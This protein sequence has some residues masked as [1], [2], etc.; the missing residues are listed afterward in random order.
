MMIKFIFKIKYFYSITLLLLL[1]QVCIGQTK[2]TLSNLSDTSQ[3]VA[4]S[5]NAPSISGYYTGHNSLYREEFAEKYYLS[6]T[7]AVVGVISFH[8][9]VNKNNNTAEFNIYEVASSR[10]PG[11]IL[12]S[13]KILYK[14]IDLQRNP[15]TT[16]FENP[17]MVQDSFF[18]SFNL[19]DYAHG[20]FEG[21]KIALLTGLD[22]SR[23][24]DDLQHSGRN[25]IRVHNHD[26]RL[27]RD[28]YTQNFTPVAT[29]FAIY[30]IVEFSSV[31]STENAFVTDENLT[32]HPTFPNPIS[33][34][35]V[36][37][38]SLAH[39]SDVQLTIYDHVGKVVYSSLNQRK[40]SGYHEE[41]INFQNFSTGVYICSIVVNQRRLALRLIKN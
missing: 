8:E 5:Y 11:K 26:V 41:N 39:T 15:M 9:G 17:V 12:G 10:L 13:Q 2:D 1:T 21:D 24:Q 38:Y 28:F 34:N 35:C 30:P 16:L 33:D 20:G 29:H 32:V 14:N 36:I 37:R 18:V 22:G 6:G 7:A 40:G 25:A 3:L 27:W 31:T 23:N 19:T 4:F